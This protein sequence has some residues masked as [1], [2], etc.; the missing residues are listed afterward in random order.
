MAIGMTP[1][2]MI[3]K[4]RCKSVGRTTNVSPLTGVRDFDE[5]RGASDDGQPSAENG[6]VEISEGMA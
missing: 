6:V 3:I 2:T 4:T 5:V 1:R